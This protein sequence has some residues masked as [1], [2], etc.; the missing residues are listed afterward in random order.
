[1]EECREAERLFAY[2]RLTCVCAEM[3]IL[4][5]EPGLPLRVVFTDFLHTSSPGDAES[6]QACQSLRLQEGLG[7]SSWFVCI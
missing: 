2:L 7:F 1:M 3:C 5:A 6:V 4:I